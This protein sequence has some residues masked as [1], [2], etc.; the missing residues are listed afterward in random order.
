MIRARFPPNPRNQGQIGLIGPANVVPQSQSAFRAAVMVHL[1]ERLLICTQDLWSSAS[2]TAVPA[3]PNF[4][5]FRTMEATVLL[6]ASLSSEGGS[7]G[8]YQ[9]I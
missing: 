8:F 5:C 3:G 4:F 2:E 9:K 1:L 7:S 6:G